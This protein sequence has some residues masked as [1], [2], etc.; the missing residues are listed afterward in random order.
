MRCRPCL[1]RCNGSTPAPARANTI[2]VNTTAD[3]TANDGK[4][5]FRE[6][7]IAA[8]TNSASGLAGECVAGTAGLDTI[9]FNIPA[10][11]PNCDAMTQ[12][13]TMTRTA[14]LPAITEAVTLNG[15]SQ[16]GALRIRTLSMQELTPSCSSN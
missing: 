7:I 13:C 16:P 12:V 3:G 2:P 6:A 15:Y 11:D 8:N 9:S 10:T 4:C 5:T 1:R 14:A